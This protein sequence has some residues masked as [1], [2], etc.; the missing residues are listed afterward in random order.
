MTPF[1]TAADGANTDWPT[2]GNDPGGS[3]YAQPTQ[4]DRSNVA[5]LTQVWSYQTGDLGEGFPSNERMAFEAT[6]ILIDGVLYVSTPYG[7]VHAIKA[8]T[9]AA[10]LGVR[11]K[12][13]ERSQLFAKTRR[14][15]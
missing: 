5:Q 10:R 9:G 11:R 1:A 6:P 13:A 15:A 8:A 4:V 14:A 7:H 3:R 2:Y 12:T